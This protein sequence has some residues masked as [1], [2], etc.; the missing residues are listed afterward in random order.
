MPPLSDTPPT[1]P[2]SATLPL[3]FALLVLA[4]S[5]DPLFVRRNFSGR[6]LLVYNLPM[7]KVVHDAWSRGSLPIWNPSISGGRPLLPNPNSG[8]LYPI[9]AALGIVPFPVA[10]RVFPVLHWTIAGVGMILL[11][12]SLNISRAGSWLGGVTYA[13]SGTG[14]SDV[15]YPHIHPGM[16]LLPWILWAFIRRTRSPARKLLLLSLLF[17]GIFLGGDVFTSGMAILSCG[18]WILRESHRAEK[19]TD[20]RL[21][22]LAILLAILLALPQIVATALWIPETNRAVLGMKIRD[23]VFF[24][25][26]P[27]RLLEFVVPFVFGRTWTLDNSDIWGWTIF[28][29]KAMGLFSTLYAGAFAAMAAVTGWRSRRPGARFAR[30]IVLFALAIAVAPSLIPAAWEGIASPLPL[31]NPEK[32]AVAFTFGLAILVGLELDRLRLRDFRWPRWILAVAVI[33]CVSAVGAAF[34]SDAIGRAAA[35]AIG[36]TSRMARTAAE[37]LPAAI[38][39]GGL[40]WVITVVALD[41]LGR[42]GKAHLATSLALLTFVPIVANRKIARTFSEEELFSPTLFARYLDRADPAREYRVLGESLYPLRTTRIGYAGWDDE[43]TDTGRR[44]WI[45][46][47]PALWGRGMVFN[48]D[49][50]AGDLISVRVT[51]S[52]INPIARALR[53]TAQFSAQ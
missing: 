2:R 11:L 24:S 8:A 9:R 18:L 33:L 36:G 30:S 23:S 40:L 39:E 37:L 34:F 6:D 29:G 53:W 4:L 19:S 25:I 52:A 38:A 46:Q 47:T 48:V 17:A 35:A 1:A 26:H 41:L 43:Y 15:F 12:L 50:D 20:F 44:L 32:F 3:L 31:R 28:R 13:L 42:P 21:L 49:F 14:M 7:E 45:H 27:L 22:I 51:P 10:M 16:A 5:V